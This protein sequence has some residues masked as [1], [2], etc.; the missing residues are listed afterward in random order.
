VYCNIDLKENVIITGPPGSAKSTTCLYLYHELKTKKI[1][2]IIFS[3]I[4]SVVDEDGAGG[5]EE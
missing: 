1:P 5:N 2:F 4:S 3:T